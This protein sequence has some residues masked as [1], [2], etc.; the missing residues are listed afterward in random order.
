MVKNG[1][2][3][4]KLY[5]WSKM[6]QNG[7]KWLEMVKNGEMVINDQNGQKLSNIVKNGQNG[8]K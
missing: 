7:Q 4:P 5:K 3:G 2:N 6:V 8:P 1:Q